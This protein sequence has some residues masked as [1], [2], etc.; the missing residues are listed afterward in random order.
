MALA[1][2]LGASYGI[3]GPA[4]ELM[5]HEPLKPGGEEYLDS[6]KYQ[7][8]HWDLHRPDSLRDYI[9]RLNRIRRENPA[10]QSDWSLSFHAIDN[11]L[12]LCY[13]K[14][15][16]DDTL[17]MVANLDPHNV[18]AGWIELPLAELGVPDD[19]PYQAHDLLSGARF[20]WQGNAQLRPPRSAGLAGAHPA[21]APPPAQRA[22]L[23]LFPLDRGHDA[24]WTNDKNHDTTAP[25]ALDWES[26]PLW[27]KDAVIYELHI[28]AYADGNGDGIGDFRGLTERL[29]HVQSL[30]VNTIWLLPFYPSPQRDDGYDVSDYENVHPSYGTLDDFRAFVTEAHRRKLRVITELVVNHTS[31]QHPWFQ[32]ARKAPKDSPERNFYVWS[33]DPKKYAGTRIIFTDYREVQLDL[34]RGRATVFLASLLQPPARSEF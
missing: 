4:Y 12:M 34:G 6:E 32:A 33:D 23:R 27:Y 18:Q 16:G 10:L 11:P 15:A 19:A 13:S 17:V 5:E 14:T 25:V 30:G 1:A 22:R 29:D 8:R 24:Q 9:T 7:L 28:K 3:Y 21:S 26:D 20:L 31:D 2:T